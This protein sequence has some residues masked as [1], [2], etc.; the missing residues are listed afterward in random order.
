MSTLSAQA[1]KGTRDYYPADKRLQNYIFGSWK[2]VAHKYGYEE[3]G[4]PMLEPLEVYTAKSD[5]T[6]DK[7]DINKLSDFI[8]ETLSDLGETY[9]RSTVPQIKALIGSIFPNGITYNQN[10]TLNHT[11]NPMYQAILSID[12]QGVSF[13]VEDGTRTRDL[14]CHRAAL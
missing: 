11:I 5:S 12:T 13:G 14:R 9:R 2:K 7:Y 1:Y 3:Y 4:A 8:K 10:G 6:L